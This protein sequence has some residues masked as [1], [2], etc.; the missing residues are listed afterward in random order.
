MGDQTLMRLL[1]ETPY[2]QTK[3]KFDG[4]TADGDFMQHRMMVYTLLRPGG[5]RHALFRYFPQ[6]ADAL[7]WEHVATMVFGDLFV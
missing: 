1:L 4:A 3:T 6:A 7:S 2:W 5:Y